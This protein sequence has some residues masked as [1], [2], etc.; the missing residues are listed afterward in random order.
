MMA[1]GNRPIWALALIGAAGHVEGFTR[2]QKYGFLAAKRIKGITKSGFYDDW[3]PSNYGPFSKELADDI[4][5]LV[6]DGLVKNEIKPN[7]YG[8]K[9]GMLTPSEIGNG[10]INEFKN[11]YRQY[12]NEIHKLVHMYQHKKLIDLLHDVYY[13]YPQYAIQSKIR[14]RVGKEIYESDSYL[15]PEY[16]DSNE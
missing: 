6:K 8:Y 15:N 9:V 4:T 2:L 13:L 14:P 3:E 1:M 5:Q 16:D 7:L 11:T 10:R 12:Y